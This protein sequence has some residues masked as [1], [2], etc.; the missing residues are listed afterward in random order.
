M[1][2]ACSSSITPRWLPE[3]TLPWP[4]VPT[5]TSIGDSGSPTSS[6]TATPTSFGS[7]LK[8]GRSVPTRLRWSL[9]S[10]TPPN[11]PMPIS[12]PELRLPLVACSPPIVVRTGWS[13]S[14]S[15]TT[16]MPA[17]LLRNGWPM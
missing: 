3:M 14:V 10:S 12:L 13:P 4:G 9:T 8:P 11:T 6:P 2:A 5:R 17:L 1:F 15:A 16:A 7:A